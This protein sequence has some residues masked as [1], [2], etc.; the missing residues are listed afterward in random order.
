[1]VNTVRRDA[2]HQDV[3]L[4]RDPSVS[5]VDRRALRRSMAGKHLSGL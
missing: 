5:V 3:I 4:S 2:H 1:M